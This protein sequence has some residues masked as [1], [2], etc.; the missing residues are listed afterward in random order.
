[1]ATFNLCHGQNDGWQKQQCVNKQHQDQNSNNSSFFIRGDT[2][3]RQSS[4]GPT[5]EEDEQREREE[6]ESPNDDA[7]ISKTNQECNHEV[8]DRRKDPD[9][10]TE[11][12][13]ELDGVSEAIPQWTG[14][15]Q[16]PVKQDEHTVFKRFH[17]YIEM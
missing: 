1:M 12:N 5:Q 6:E 14:D 8:T 15:E 17:I 3:G 10:N 16:I 9:H 2:T 4:D 7:S 13:R 11:N